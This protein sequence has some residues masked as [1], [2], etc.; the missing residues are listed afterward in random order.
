MVVKSF[1]PIRAGCAS[2]AAGGGAEDQ[3]HPRDLRGP[4]L[5][6]EP[7]RRRRRRLGVRAVLLHHHVEHGEA[8]ES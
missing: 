7:L 3:P 5:R 1:R 2:L 6:G 8:V 4:L